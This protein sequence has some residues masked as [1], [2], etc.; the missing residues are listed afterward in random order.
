M[1]HL[2]VH[3]S[4]LSW[5]SGGGWGWIVM[6][7]TLATLRMNRKT[8]PTC[9]S[10]STI[11]IQIF[12]TIIPDNSSKLNK[13]DNTITDN[14]DTVPFLLIHIE[15]FSLW[16]FYYDTV[17]IAN[18]WKQKSFCLQRTKAD[19]HVVPSVDVVQ[20]PWKSHPV[21]IEAKLG[22]QNY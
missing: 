9:P 21:L 22:C 8:M 12:W 14:S 13:V 6:S 10:N 3:C 17:L 4:I 7:R 20:D 15:H 1:Q 11:T 18:K 16:Y 5:R 2:Y 19:L